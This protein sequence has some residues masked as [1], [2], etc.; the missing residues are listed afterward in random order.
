MGKIDRIISN[1]NEKMLHF[2]KQHIEIKTGKTK[3]ENK[4]KHYNPPSSRLGG[5]I[6]DDYQ[7]SQY[8]SHESPMTPT[9]KLLEHQ[10]KKIRNKKDSYDF[11][12]K[13]P[14]KQNFFLDDQDS[15]G[16]LF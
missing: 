12:L 5:S 7:S 8:V 15:W 3:I 14:M 4:K 2:D 9:E 10:S 6:I 13:N 16:M 11:K 1:W